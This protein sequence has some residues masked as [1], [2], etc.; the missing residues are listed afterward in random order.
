MNMKPDTVSVII[1]GDLCMR[2]PVGALIGSG[3]EAGMFEE[4]RSLWDGDDLRIV[5]L[6]NPLIDGGVPIHKSGPN[7]KSPENGVGL[8]IA[9]GVDA[10][11]LANN[12]IG[13]YGD[14]GVLRTLSI[15]DAHGIGYMGAGANIDMARQPWF[16]RRKG[17]T[18]AVLAAAENEFG[19]A[20]A[21]R[22]GSNGLNLRR[23]CADIAGARDRA[24]FVLV[25]MHGG[26][27]YNP[28]PSPV[29]VD[30]Y[31]ALVDAGADAVIGMHPHCPQGYEI[32]R[33]RPIVY[34]TGNFLFGSAARPDPQ[35]PWYYGYLPRIVL[36]GVAPAL[37]VHPYRFTPDLTRIHMMTGGE[38]ERMLAYLTEIS[39]YIADPEKL[40]PHYESWCALQGPKM[41]RWLAWSPDTPD[42]G[43]DSAYLALRNLFTC[44]AHNDLMKTYL[45]AVCDGRIAQCEQGIPQV[46]ALQRMP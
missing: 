36:G 24:D 34:S 5:N 31:R 46:I 32:Y 1:A 41:A 17:Y 13:D 30:R 35:D 28:V 16:V 44:E 18:L 11:V 27:E 39:A 21:E 3:R 4:V 12:H 19:T 10:V 43:S 26:N 8:L 23:L 25:V 38:K 40:W 37:T 14:E 9:A 45:R 42:P 7:L 20:T 22:P 6:E 2:E 15:L 33:D 29:V